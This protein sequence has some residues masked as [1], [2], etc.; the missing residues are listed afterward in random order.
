MLNSR[1]ISIMIVHIV[2][3]EHEFNLQGGGNRIVWFGLT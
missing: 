2:S 1:K 3:A